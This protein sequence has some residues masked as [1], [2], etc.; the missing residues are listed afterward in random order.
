AAAAAKQRRA[1]AAKRVGVAERA[2]RAEL[3]AAQKAYAARSRA[4]R[5]A[6]SRVDTRTRALRR[7]NRAVVSRTAAVVLARA[8]VTADRRGSTTPVAPSAPSAPGPIVVAPVQQGAPVRKVP[9][10]PAPAPSAAAPTSPPTPTPTPPSNTGPTA[11]FSYT[12]TDLSATFDASAS[13]DPDGTIVAYAWDLGDGARASGRTVAHRYASAGSYPV[14]LTVTDDD[15]ASTT[16][17]AVVS[18]TAPPAAATAS[19]ARDGWVETAW[20]GGGSGCSASVA[21][22]AW[23]TDDACSTRTV[24]DV[25]AV[26]DPNTG[27]AVFDTAAIDQGYTADGWLVVGGT[28]LAAP[29][30]AGMLVRSGRAADHS[31][32]GALYADRS[33]FWDV[34]SGSN[35]SCGTSSVCNAGVGYDGPTGLGTPKSLDSF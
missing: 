29:L 21:K 5:S 33:A 22:P 2:G 11:G 32:A 31:D 25:A 34:T 28:S 26:G 30:I 12:A 9:L 1:T 18:V 24:A 7:A 16:T 3:R 23:Q 19:A 27:L 17:R 13:R 10:S 4:Y 35:G 14:S 8:V 20:V 15:G 6:T